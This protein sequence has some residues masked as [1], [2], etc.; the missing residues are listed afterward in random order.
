MKY[1]TITVNGYWNAIP[2]LGLPETEPFENMTVALGSWDGE[3][4][5]DDERIF[6]YL[7]GKTPIGDHGEFTITEIIEG[8]V[9]TYADKAKAWIQNAP[10][11]DIPVGRFTLR[12]HMTIS[13]DWGWSWDFMNWLLPKDYFDSPEDAYFEDIYHSMTPDLHDMEFVDALLEA[14]KNKP[15]NQGESK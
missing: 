10:Y 15:F 8:E 14:M 7:D 5:A 3:E 2:E 1:Q 12:F 4:D 9:M 13:R 6:F 11:V